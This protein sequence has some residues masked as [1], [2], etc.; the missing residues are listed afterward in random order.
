[1]RVRDVQP[2]RAAVVVT[3]ALLSGC[4]GYIRDPAGVAGADGGPTLDGTVPGDGGPGVDGAT[5]DAGFPPGPPQC[6]DGIDN[7]GDGLVDWQYDLGCWGAGDVT[8][9]GRSN[10][11]EDGWTVF[12][13]S[14]DTRIVY[15]SSSVGDDAWTG[16][17]PEPNGT[18]GPKK[19]VAAGIAQLR[20]GSPDWLLI[21]RGDV[22][23][24]E[25][26]GNW[27]IS[28]RS[29]SEPAVIA[30]YGS[31][32]DRPRFEVSR[33]FFET[34]NGGGVSRNRSH[35]R[36]LGLHVLSYGKDPDDPRF[37][38]QGGSCI[39]WLQE[40][41]DFLAEDI[42]CEFAQVNL[43]GAPT[44]PISI[45]RSVLTE[46]YSLNSHAQSIFSIVHSPLLLEENVVHHGGSSNRFR[47]AMW[48]P[49]TDPAVWSAI[50]DGQVYFVFDGQAF[51]LVNLDFTQASSMTGVANVLQAG[52]RGVT[53]DAT[54]EVSFSSVGR[55]FQVRA[56]NFPEGEIY[57]V[58][59]SSGAPGGTDLFP[60][61]VGADARGPAQGSPNSTIFNRNHYIASSYG[62]TVMR[63]NVDA[64]GASGG[65]QLRMGGVYENNL[66]LR[67]AHALVIGSNENAGGP[68][69]GGEVLNNVALGA[70]DISTQKQGTGFL[71]IST[72]AT[73][74]GAGS[75]LI[76]GLSVHDN[77]LAHNELGTYN[78]RALQVEGDGPVR[79]V[80][81]Y[82]NVV[83]DWARPSWED[84]MDQRALGFVFLT[85][86]G[87]SNIH[88]H[89]NVLH[90]PNGGFLVA[91]FANPVG[92][93]LEN[94]TYWSAA[95][96]PPD[97]WS[98]GWYF[99]AR[100]TTTEEWQAATGETGMQEGR[101]TYVDPDRTIE[102]Y[103]AS[104]GETPTYEAY[105]DL[106][107]KQS[108]HAWRPEL[109]APVINDYIRAGFVVDTSR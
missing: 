74:D 43:Q 23:V 13:P 9:G 78:I 109:T 54:I 85:P 107:L 59:T 6:N 51:S 90:Q 80:E 68:D 15:V 52:L 16:L 39:Q 73:R 79:D 102:T 83:Y 75:S 47:L 32:V 38:G 36:L 101:V 87:S 64:D 8:E 31:A 84:P 48:V 4:Y 72:Q 14:A 2:R 88:V 26:L 86:D 81:V 27:P 28:G 30:T 33:T 96:N 70:R 37:M 106:A 5:P 53:G 97:V 18:D 99:I 105:I 89:D 29:E 95:P 58:R 66:S 108:K 57:E 63:G 7:D 22:F 44:L 104:I 25:V 61:L 69:I 21:R 17:V 35:V 45:R 50:S 1:M 98:R 40:G 71:F 67:N 94:N 82:R 65:A 76:N 91:T 60:L 55:T 56:P 49:E 12:E 3:C 10:A 20:D 62:N 77:I 103:M 41:G 46:S 42:K 100:S 34:I 19:T 92:L 24:D 93:R 11:L